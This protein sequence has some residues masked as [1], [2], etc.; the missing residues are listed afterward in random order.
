MKK[1]SYYDSTTERFLKHHRKNKVHVP[2]DKNVKYK[3]KKK[4]QKEKEKKGY[5]DHGKIS[6]LLGFDNSLSSTGN[7]SS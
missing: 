2:S 3:K 4:N 1:H 6:C 7:F 5:S